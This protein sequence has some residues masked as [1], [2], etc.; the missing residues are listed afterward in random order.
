MN[1]EKMAKVLE[2][3]YNANRPRFEQRQQPQSGKVN[4]MD[5]L[6]GIIAEEE[7]GGSQ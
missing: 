5:V 3:K 1:S 6:A 4:T 7:G 2:G